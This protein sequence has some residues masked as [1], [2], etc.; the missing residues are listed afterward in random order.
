MWRLGDVSDNSLLLYVFYAGRPQPDHP[1]SYYPNLV[2]KLAISMPINS[3]KKLGITGYTL[4]RSI[5][6]FL[7]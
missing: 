7:R 1:S 2:N 3:L 6:S 5:V 4:R